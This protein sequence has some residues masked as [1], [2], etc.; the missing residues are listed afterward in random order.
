M[1][2]VQILRGQ[3]TN[4]SVQEQRED[5]CGVPIISRNADSG[6]HLERRKLGNGR[7]QSQDQ[8]VTRTIHRRVPRIQRRCLHR[9][10][11]LQYSSLLFTCLLV[12]PQQVLDFESYRAKRVQESEEKLHEL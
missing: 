12:E 5:W 3:H 6:Q 8:L 1:I 7:G 9:S 2:W 10:S 4:Q 11:K